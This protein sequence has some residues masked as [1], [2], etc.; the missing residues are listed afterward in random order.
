MCEDQRV[1]RHLLLRL[2]DA[3]INVLLPE[4]R[5]NISPSRTL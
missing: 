3:D 4:I 5:S 2:G 1:L